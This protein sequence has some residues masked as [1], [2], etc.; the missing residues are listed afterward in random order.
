MGWGA[1]GVDKEGVGRH[2]SRV[3]ELR[4]GFGMH[5]TLLLYFCFCHLLQFRSLGIRLGVWT[6]TIGVQITIE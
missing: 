6:P 2:G 1:A 5:I 4:D 3:R